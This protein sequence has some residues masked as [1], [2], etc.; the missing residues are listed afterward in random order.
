MKVTDIAMRNLCMIHGYAQTVG[1]TMK[2]IMMIINIV[3]SVG[4]L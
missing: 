3:L 1:N 2:W 4:R